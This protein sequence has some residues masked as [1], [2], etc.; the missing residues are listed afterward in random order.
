LNDNLGKR[1]IASAHRKAAPWVLGRAGPRQPVRMSSNMT[2]YGGYANPK[3]L[4]FAKEVVEANPSITLREL[5][6]IIHNDSESSY[7]YIWWMVN[8]AHVRAI[9]EDADGL[10][11]VRLEKLWQ[12]AYPLSAVGGL[13]GA[14]SWGNYENLPPNSYF[15][16]YENEKK[17]FSHSD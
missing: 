5:Q 12:L 3:G 6:E 13:A 1:R 7:D 14:Q 16:L 10:S 17:A 2:V 15:V 9:H 4:A 8:K 11:F